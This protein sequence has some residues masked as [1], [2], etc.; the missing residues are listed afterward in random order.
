MLAVIVV[1][2]WAEAVAW[3]A[4]L[5]VVLVLIILVARWSIRRG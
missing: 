5:A 2:E 3:T 4:F 1:P